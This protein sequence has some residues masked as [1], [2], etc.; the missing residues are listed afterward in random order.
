MGRWIPK[1]ACLL[2]VALA[3]PA[4]SAEAV[5]VTWTG[6]VD[7]S[8][9]FF[10][11]AVPVGST[12][13]LIAEFTNTPIDTNPDN[14]I[15]RYTV[16]VAS[17]SANNSD[18]S[19]FIQGSLELVVRNNFNTGTATLDR[20]T[21]ESD[22]GPDNILNIDLAA[23]DTLLPNDSFPPDTL[24]ITDF[25]DPLTIDPTYTN[26]NLSFTLSGASLMGTVTNITSGP[27]MPIIPL[28]TAA[29]AALP[30]LGMV[31]LRRRTR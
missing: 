19:P 29:T 6:V 1:T 22:R 25:P 13:E 16:D 9:S 3:A 14:A 28:P 4:A 30:L 12:W 17:F 31:L 8:T 27:P 24:A 20:I 2:T 18:L 21:F 5:I 10:A 15:G 26:R 7:T 11:T 23:A